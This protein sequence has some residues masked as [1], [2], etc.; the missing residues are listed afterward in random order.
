MNINEKVWSA[1]CRCAV[2]TYILGTRRRFLHILIGCYTKSPLEK[3]RGWKRQS[4]EQALLFQSTDE[5]AAG[6]DDQGMVGFKWETRC[7]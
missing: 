7:G 1:R 5:L 2:Q 4:M 6:K 3:A